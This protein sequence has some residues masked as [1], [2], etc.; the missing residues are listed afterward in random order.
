MLTAVHQQCQSSLVV[1]GQES[2]EATLLRDAINA[3]KVTKLWTFYGGPSLAL[4]FTSPNGSIGQLDNFEKAAKLDIGSWLKLYF[5][6]TTRP[7]GNA[8]SK[9]ESMGRLNLNLKCKQVSL[10]HR[11][12]SNYRNLGSASPS[13]NTYLQRGLWAKLWAILLPM[14][15]TTYNVG[16]SYQINSL[17]THYCS[18]IWDHT[19][20]LEITMWSNKYLW[21]YSR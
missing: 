14:K 6:W 19:S 16:L 5:D 20:G 4:A 9:K 13:S 15:V 10:K 21:S 2:E 12:S 11:S 17:D 18:T 3:K 1:L 8:S 7:W